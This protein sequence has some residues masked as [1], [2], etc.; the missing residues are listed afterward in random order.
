MV[1]PSIRD[2]EYAVDFLVANVRFYSFWFTFVI[3]HIFFIIVIVRS[4]GKR[5]PMPDDHDDFLS[6]L[7][8]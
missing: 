2:P 1:Y 4:F 8:G 7:P 6:E 3:A 5:T